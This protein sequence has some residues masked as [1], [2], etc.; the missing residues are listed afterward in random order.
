[1]NDR[2]VTGKIMEQRLDIKNQKLE[3]NMVVYPT[4]GNSPMATTLIKNFL[5][6]F[7]GT[8]LLYMKDWE[9]LADS[10]FI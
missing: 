10:V 1:M 2:G 8:L 3:E 7:K 9:V 4:N 5:R 6:S